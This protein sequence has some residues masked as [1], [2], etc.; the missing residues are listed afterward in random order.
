MEKVLEKYKNEYH[1]QKAHQQVKDKEL[2]EFEAWKEAHVFQLRE[3]L[4]TVKSTEN[5]KAKSVEKASQ[6]QEKLELGRQLEVE[7]E[8]EK[9]QPEESKIE[10]P[11]DLS[12][13]LEDL[14]LEHSHVEEPILEQEVD[15]NAQ[16]KLEEKLENKKDHSMESSME[17]EENQV[18][19]NDLKSLSTVNKLNFICPDPFRDAKE[20]I[21][22]LISS[23]LPP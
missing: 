14:I 6:Q 3:Q 5:M 15:E 1:D 7:D 13:E 17:I 18:I 11:E 22:C 21:K 10:E 4:D 16:E 12:L 8:I 9:E 2:E 20:S 19:H 23:L